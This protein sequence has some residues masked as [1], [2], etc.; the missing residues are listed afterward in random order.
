M[1]SGRWCVCL[2]VAIVVGGCSSAQQSSTEEPSPATA[3]PAETVPKTALLPAAET[4][5]FQCEQAAVELGF[6]VPCPSQLPTVDGAAPTCP[7]S[8]VGQAGGGDTL[9]EVFF[10]GV[11]DFDGADRLGSTRHLVVEARRLADAPLLPCF[12]GVDANDAHPTMRLLTCV[13]SSAELQANVQHG[14]GAHAGHILGYWDDAGVRY[15][16]SVHG[17]G[18]QNRMLVNEVFEAISLVGP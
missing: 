2:A 16:I 11:A 14:E 1:L 18:D 15:S 4:L 17:D 7:V 8:C 13:E 9:H 10:L 12:G 6:A 3:A 5:R